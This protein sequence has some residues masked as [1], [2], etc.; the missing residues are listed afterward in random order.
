MSKWE[1]GQTLPDIALLPVLAGIFE[2]SI[3]A[4]LGYLTSQNKISEYESRYREQEYY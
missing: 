3:D 2:V 4:L 1:T